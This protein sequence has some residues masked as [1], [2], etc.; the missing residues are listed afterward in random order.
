MDVDREVLAAAERPAHAGQ[1]EPHLLGRQAESEADLA[2]VDVQPLGGDV[3]VDAAVLGRHG[4]PGLRAEEGLVL[5]ADLEVQGDRRPGRSGSA[6]RRSLRCRTRL[7]G[8][9]TAGASAV[10]RPARV[11]DG[12]QHLV[13]D[14]D[15]L[16]P[17]GE[18]SPDGRRR[19]APPARPRSGR[20][21]RPAPAGRR[22]RGR[23]R[24]PRDVVGGEYGPHARHG[25]G[26]GDVDAPDARV[27]MRAAQRDAPRH[28]VVPQVAGVGELTGDLQRPVRPQRTVPDPA[29][30]HGR[31]RGP[32][33]GGHDSACRSAASRTASRIF[34]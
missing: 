7:P 6:P 4:E 27:R 25:R 10:H 18:R 30:R 11:G 32:R 21:P 8:R 19:R 26:V 23:R 22:A 16:R 20:T 29:R 14:D 24:S 13:V 12:G 2:L 3:Q 9:C 17:R 5:H 1:R 33:V 31:R 28:L 34:S 15:P